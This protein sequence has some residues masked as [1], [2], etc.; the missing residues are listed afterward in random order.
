[1]CRAATAGQAAQGFTGGGPVQI[2]RDPVKGRQLLAA[3]QSAGAELVEF[4]GATQPE[5]FRVL[6]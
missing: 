5:D 1:M 4:A 3:R 6:G 2:V